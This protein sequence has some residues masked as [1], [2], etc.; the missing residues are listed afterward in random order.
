MWYSLFTLKTTTS[1][2]CSRSTCNV[3][4]WTRE[5][6][7]CTWRASFCLPCVIFGCCYITVDSSTPA[8][9]NDACTERWI[10]EQMHLIM[11]MLHNCS[12]TTQDVI[13]CFHIKANSLQIDASHRTIHLHSTK[14]L[15]KKKNFWWR[16]RF[17]HIF[18]FCGSSKSNDLILNRLF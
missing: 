6:S 11:L 3:W 12:I 18:L 17:V 16:C 15:C 8:P 10:S 5:L 9:W 1:W 14:D 2:L 4:G 13:L 7:Y